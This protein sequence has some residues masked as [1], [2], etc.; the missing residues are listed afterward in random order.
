MSFKN[1]GLR[2]AIFDRDERKC[3]RCGSDEEL[4][5][6]HIVPRARGGSNRRENLQTL[7]FVCNNKKAG[8]LPTAKELFSTDEPLVR[9]IRGEHGRAGAEIVAP[10][11]KRWRG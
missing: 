3:R 4:T 2:E 6:D 9:A 8:K 1:K 11:R 7:C 10:M 5:L